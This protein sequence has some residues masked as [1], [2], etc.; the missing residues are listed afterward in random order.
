MVCSVLRLALVLLAAPL[1]GAGAESWDKLKPGMTP[2]ETAAAL[3]QSLF[4][5][6]GRDFEIGIYD[7]RAEVVFLRG[8]LV[9]WTSPASLSALPAPSRADIWQFNQQWRPLPNARVFG[10]PVPS[11]RP[12]SGRGTF[13]PSYRL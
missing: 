3:G 10:T 5:S 4:A 11:P 2:E 12:P 13:L 7:R 9:A 6:R 1:A 8:Q